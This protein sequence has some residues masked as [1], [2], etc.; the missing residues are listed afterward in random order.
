MEIGQHVTIRLADSTLIGQVD[1]LDNDS[2]VVDGT[3]VRRQDILSVDVVEND[4]DS[5]YCGSCGHFHEPDGVCPEQ[6]PCGDYRC[7]IN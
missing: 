1:G 4:G 3:H 6:S 5:D 7:C 2:I